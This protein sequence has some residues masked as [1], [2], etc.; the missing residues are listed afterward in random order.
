M[1]EFSNTWCDW[2]KAFIQGG[3]VGIKVNDQVGKNFQTLK[4]LRKGDP[5]SPI[6]FNIVVDILAILLTD[7]KRRVK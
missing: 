7:H 3:H 5:L 6:R 1:K 2:I 4:G